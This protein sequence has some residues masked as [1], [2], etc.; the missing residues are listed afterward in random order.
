MKNTLERIN[1]KL[2]DTEEFITKLE[3]IIVEITNQ[4]NNKKRVYV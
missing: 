2:G 1:N 4:K 3:N